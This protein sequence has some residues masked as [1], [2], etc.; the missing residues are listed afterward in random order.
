MVK[1]IYDFKNIEDFESYLRLLIENLDKYLIRYKSYHR[2][3]KKLCLEKY[4]EIE[5][6]AKD[7]NSDILLKMIISDNYIDTREN[8]SPI[9][10]KKYGKYKDMVTYVQ[11][12]ILN[13]IGDRTK[14][15]A[16][17]YKFRDAVK[18]YNNNFEPKILLDELTQDIN[19]KL[20]GCYRSRNYLAHTGDS[21]FIS[22]IEYRR[23]QAEEWKEQS[24]LDFEKIKK[25]KIIVN[26]YDYVDIEW[27][28]ELLI[29]YERAIPIYISLHQQ[30]RRDLNKI[31]GRKIEIMQFP[32]KTLPFDFAVISKHSWDM[33]FKSKK[34]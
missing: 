10:Y 6:E 17:Y 18:K 3:I 21:V 9:T 19:E 8:F 15:A 30:M 12:K 22:Q 32:S 5:P 28:F 20:N 23:K 14:E 33:Q 29:I 2:E 11:L 4:Q 27:L 24:G 13:I 26:K 7:I 16:S 25:D 1:V 31:S 34:K